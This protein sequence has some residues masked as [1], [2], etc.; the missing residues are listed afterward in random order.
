VSSAITR[1]E[2]THLPRAHIDVTIALQQHDAYERCLTDLGYRVDRLPA[3]DDM[4]DSVFVE[5]A[6]V[7]FGEVGLI[8]RPGAQSRRGELAAVAEALGRYRTL[9]YIEPPGTLDGGDVLVIG[10]RLFA[11]RSSRTNDDGIDQM[12]RILGPYGYITEAVDVTGCLH[13]K[14]AVTS[15]GRDTVLMNRS[16]TTADRFA[17]FTI[18]D[19]EPAEPC[20]ANALR[21]GETIV[22]PA[23]FPRTRRRLEARGFR[24]RT[25]PA[26]ELAKAEGGVTCCSL[27]VEVNGCAE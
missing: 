5:D 23:E 7:A 24:V 4:P 9:R 16:W 8:T 21:L 22:Y 15:I 27:I 12:R 6:A 13:L 3:G 1:C 19:V 2:L 11:G 20:A 17:A 25:V 10:R 26:G 14:S 18:I